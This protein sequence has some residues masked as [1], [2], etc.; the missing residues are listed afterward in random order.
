MPDDNKGP[1][2]I[3]MDTV[4]RYGLGGL[5]AGAGGAAAIN[6]VHLISKLNEK[7]KEK[8]PTATDENTIVLTLPKRAADLAELGI[9]AEGTYNDKPDLSGKLEGHAEEG[10]KGDADEEP[11]KVK[12]VEGD[13][14]KV[15]SAAGSKGTEYEEG[16]KADDKTPKTQ[17]PEAEGGIQGSPSK[18]PLGR[19]PERESTESN[20]A[21]TNTSKEHNEKKANWPTLTAALLAAGAGGATGV[22]LVNKAY[23]M[24]RIKDKEKELEGAKKEYLDRL[25]KGA[26][27]E[28]LDSMFDKVAV[29]TDDRRT[30]GFMDYPMGLSA[31]MLL[32]GSGGSA[33]LT[34]R[35]LDAGTDEPQITPARPKIKRIVFQSGDEK[36]SSA[37][38]QAAVQGTIDATVGI[39]ADIVSGEPDVLMNEKC[40]AYLDKRNIKPS[41]LYKE[42]QADFNKLVDRIYGDDDLRNTIQRAYLEAHP[43]GKYFKWG[44]KLPGVSGLADRKMYGKLKEIFEPR[45]MFGPKLPEGLGKQ[46]AFSDYV[47]SQHEETGLPLRLTINTGANRPV[48]QS[49]VDM[50]VGAH[51]AA[52][53]DP[54]KDVITANM[55]VGP[56]T[57]GRDEPMLASLLGR[58]SQA[59]IKDRA[60]GETA[61]SAGLGSLAG[62]PLGALSSLFTDQSLLEGAGTGGAIGAGVGGLAKLI[63]LIRQYRNSADLSD[64]PIMPYNY[65]TAAEKKAFLGSNLADIAASFYGSTIANKATELDE[66]KK[67]QEET[68]EEEPESEETPEERATR[69]LSGL[70][71]HAKDPQAAQFVSENREA[72]IQALSNMAQEGK[73]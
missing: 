64:T 30:F 69:I 44:L 41:D 65:K 60:I 31:L 37:D 34:K 7:R 8:D 39:F 21:N 54:K 46:S 32:L 61:E 45:P 36:Q 52:F 10:I 1:F 72:L 58:L 20:S 2:N 62:L 59:G 51:P 50:G 24:K 35:I 70:E 28:L 27:T 11:I 53:Y 43:I 40:A 14:V 66:D 55:T 29:Q 67:L 9:N 25:S 63:D 13:K 49:S 68:V 33:Y 47:H 12:D 17:G 71:V 16:I 19:K 42:A 3:N 57:T 5:A 73:I 23:E 4:T 48:G 6:L 18:E 22:A 15:K 38:D 56:N 26:S